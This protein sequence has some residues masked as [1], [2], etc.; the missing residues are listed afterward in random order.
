MRRFGISEYVLNQASDLIF[1]ASSLPNKKHYNFNLMNIMH[2]IEIKR[3]GGKN[4]PEYYQIRNV[5]CPK[6]YLMRIEKNLSFLDDAFVP[7]YHM[8][9]HNSWGNGDVSL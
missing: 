5:L 6:H 3:Q 2:W 9:H 7:F 8:K 4:G 1:F